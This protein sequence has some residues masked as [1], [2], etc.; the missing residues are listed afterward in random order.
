M[1]YRDDGSGTT[2]PPNDPAVRRRT[3]RVRVR[4]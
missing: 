4:R 3:Y 2:P 1:E